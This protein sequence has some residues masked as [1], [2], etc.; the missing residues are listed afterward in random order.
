MCCTQ[1]GYR[2]KRIAKQSKRENIVS[3][4]AGR[5]RSISR[6]AGFAYLTIS[7]S[8]GKRSQWLTCCK[9]IHGAKADCLSFLRQTHRNVRLDLELLLVSVAIC[10]FMWRSPQRGH[11]RLLG[12]WYRN[13]SCQPSQS[14]SIW[15]LIT[16][17]S[18]QH[19][20]ITFLVLFILLSESFPYEDTAPC[21]DGGIPS[22]FLLGF[23]ST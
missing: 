23:V 3:L 20:I 22:E 17:I 19:N 13:S 10:T 9:F 7:Q 4:R 16:S 18:L 11:S 12:H 15:C 2:E 1:L 6:D 8:V 21:L 14:S 5:R